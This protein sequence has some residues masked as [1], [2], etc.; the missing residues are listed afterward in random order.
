[1]GWTSTITPHYEISLVLKAKERKF[2]LDGCG[3]LPS[4]FF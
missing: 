4:C 2:L 1:M 3:R